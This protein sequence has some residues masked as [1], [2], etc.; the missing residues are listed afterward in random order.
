MKVTP[1]FRECLSD[2][3]TAGSAVRGRCA[4]WKRGGASANSTCAA[5]CAVTVVGSY[6]GATSTTS[7]P[8]TFIPAR[9]RRIASASR[10]VRPPIP[11]CRFRHKGR[12]E[13]VDVERDI[14]RP[15]ADDRARLGDDRLDAHLVDVFGMDDG[16]AAFV[17]ELPE[18]F[19]TS[20]DADLDRALSD[21]ARRP[22]PPCGKARRDGTWRLRRGRSCRSARRNA[23]CRP[24]CRGPAP[25]GS[26]R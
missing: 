6:C 16:H 7:A 1:A 14:D 21:R 24:A 2:R 8:T 9:P 20:A 4:R 12:I 22:A 15:V 5:F 18:I 13:P 10:I 19:S 11:A 25:S 23:P 26:A 17:R 3:V